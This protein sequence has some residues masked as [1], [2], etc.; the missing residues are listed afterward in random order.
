MDLE[1][2]NRLSGEEVRSLLRPCL[3]VD[4][5]IDAVA[6]GRPYAD[7]DACLSVARTGAHPLSPEEIE[8]AMAHHPRIGERAGG[9][10]VEARQ[11]RQEQ[12]GL[13]SL[14][15]SVSER[16]AEGNKAYEERFDRVF[17]IRAAGRTPEEILAELER[18]M[19]NSPEDEL[20]ETG[21]QLEQIA[22]LRLE[23]I[24]R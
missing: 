12:A 8:S 6:Q 18:R 19:Q 1:D 4:R 11:S 3:D 15:G 24:L 10:S 22:A 9:D 2:F 13:G 16:L 20:T 21:E 14:E 23:G 5:W 17:L 7:V